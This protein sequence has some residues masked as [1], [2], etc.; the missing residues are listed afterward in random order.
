VCWHLD[1]QLESLGLKF[2]RYADDSIVWPN[3]YARICR[4]FDIVRDFSS[5]TGVAVNV[6]KSEGIGLLVKDG[7]RSDSA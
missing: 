1:K 7:L 6:Q 3:D 5:E 4:S 2:A